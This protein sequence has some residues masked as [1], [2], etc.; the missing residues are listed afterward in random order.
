MNLIT[1]AD[2][3]RTESQRSAV[4]DW[5]NVIGAS[6]LSLDEVR[7]VLRVIPHPAKSQ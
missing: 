2:P 4:R 6:T 7:A 5:Y 3:T 1:F